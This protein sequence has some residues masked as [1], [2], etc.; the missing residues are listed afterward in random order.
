MAVR[1]LVFGAGWLGTQWAARHAAAVLTSTD[2]ADEEAVANELDTFKPV[3][4]VNAAG[5]TGHPNIDALE[6]HP[7]STYRSNVIGPLVLA[8]ACRQRDLHMTHIGSGCIYTGDNGGAGFAETDPPNFRGSLY[9]RSKIAAEQ[10][11][12]EF[13]VLQLR[14]RLPIASVPAPRNLL[15]KL[16]A[17]E[18]VIRVPNSITVLD[19]FW[20][21]AE[22]LILRSETG[23][24][25]LVNDGV[26]LHD[27]LLAL[28]RERVD[29]SHRVEVIDPQTLDGELRAARSNCVLSTAKLHAAG[30]GM[31]PLAESLPR[32]VDAYAAHRGAPGHR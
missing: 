30:L 21:P 4:V 15:T 17:F 6:D 20:E 27:D 7:A 13:D 24:W 22:A 16:I 8:A 25:N 5:K 18:R 31:P 19:D 14:I 3:R 10:S 9:A 32:L 11:L 12:A 23:I 28:W 29:P 2:I 26:E 1:T